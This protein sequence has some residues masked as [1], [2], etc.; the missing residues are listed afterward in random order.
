MPTENKCKVK[1]IPIE[2]H[3][4]AG[5]MN[6][7]PEV[8]ILPWWMNF[9][10]ISVTYRA[11]IE[12]IFQLRAEELGITLILDHPISEEIERGEWD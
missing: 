10:S 1:F 5:T 4:E 11:K 7:F 6:N 9:P 3:D 8:P 12:Q 2:W